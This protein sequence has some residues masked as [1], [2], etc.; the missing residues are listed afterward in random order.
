M[1]RALVIIMIAT[2]VL[3]LGCFGGVVGL[4]GPD[5]AR[6]GWVWPE[7]WRQYGIHV[8][9]DGDIS[10]DS[11]EPDET[12]ELTWAGGPSLQ[13]DLPAEVVFTQGAETKVVVSG[14]RSVIDRIAFEG[15]R[16][17]FEDDSGRRLR[18]GLTITISAPSVTRFVVNGASRLSIDD[19]DQ[20]ELAVEINGSGDVVASGKA[21][22]VTISVAG[23][24][25]ADLGGVQ[26]RDVA[27]DI[28]GS[29][30]A[31]ASPTGN[32]KVSIAGSGDVNLL[33][34]PASL[35]KDVA[36]SGDV[37]VDD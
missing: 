1:V 8:D 13:L 28:A 29:G 24:G 35:E 2:F 4:G 10:T 7:K 33:S 30:D 21:G 32:A 37:H 36:G 26:T 27:I 22:K 9:S 3:A 31:T 17:H 20:P 12:R 19:Y 14:P 18:E 5:L 34:K 16:L 23:S 11:D 25:K 15:D 6:N